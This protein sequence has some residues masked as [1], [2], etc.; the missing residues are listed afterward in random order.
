MDTLPSPLACGRFMHMDINTSCEHTNQ[1]EKNP[2]PISVRAGGR[3]HVNMGRTGYFTWRPSE[4]QISAQES[5]LWSCLLVFLREWKLVSLSPFLLSSF[6]AHN[7]ASVQG[8]G[9]LCFLG[10]FFCYLVSF[11]PLPHQTSCRPA[12]LDSCLLVFIELRERDGG[13][14]C[15]RRFTAGSHLC[16]V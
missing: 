12:L 5:C 3:V 7:R 14:L 4:V 11:C 6:L 1:G 9:P 2:L 8:F 15:F 13:W 16:Q 10:A